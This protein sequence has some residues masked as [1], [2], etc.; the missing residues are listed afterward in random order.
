MSATWGNPENIYPLGGLP[1]VPQLG[2]SKDPLRAAANPCCTA[3]PTS[4][5]KARTLAEQT[6]TDTVQRL[7]VKLVGGLSRD[8]AT[9]VISGVYGLSKVSPRREGRFSAPRV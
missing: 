9:N 5:R 4:T 1:H 8:V 3:M 7:Y 6:P 2:R